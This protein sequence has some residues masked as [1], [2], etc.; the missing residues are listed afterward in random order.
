MRNLVLL[1]GL[2]ACSTYA[3]YAAQHCT[4]YGLTP[5][6]P[7]FAQCAQQE[8]R[9]IALAAQR[10]MVY[11]LSTPPQPIKSTAPAMVQCTPNYNGGINCTER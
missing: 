4:A 7:E 6:T 5:G 10:P 9:T 2:S 3:D 1:L 11:Q 8:A